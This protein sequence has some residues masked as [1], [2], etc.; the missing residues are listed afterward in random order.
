M[1]SRIPTG[2]INIKEDNGSARNWD[3]FGR[4][5]PKSEIVFFFQVILIYIIVITAIVNLTLN[6]DEGKIW[7]ALLSSCLGYL[8][9]S[10][11]IKDKS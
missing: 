10:P 5:L 2:D 8:L 1:D 4:R 9:P 6:Q 7:I 11:S 3:F